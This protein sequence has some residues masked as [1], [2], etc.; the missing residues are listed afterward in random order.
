MHY[1]TFEPAL[2]SS[3]A[4]L[5]RNQMPIAYFQSYLDLARDIGLDPKKIMQD[6]GIPA[7]ILDAPD[8]RISIQKYFLLMQLIANHSGDYS[9]GFELGLRLP[10]TAH[11]HLSF[12]LLCAPDLK[13]ALSLAQ[14][15]WHLRSSG[16]Y[17]SLDVQDG[18]CAISFYADPAMPTLYQQVTLEA[19]VIGFYLALQF[20]CG[21]TWQAEIWFSNPEPD[22]FARYKD[23]FAMVSYSKPA[24]Q[25]RFAA[26]WLET[27][28]VTHHPHALKAAIEL[29]ERENVLFSQNA[30]DIVGQVRS[31]IVLGSEGYP[32]AEDIAAHLNLTPRT[33]R[34]KL[35]LDHTGYKQLLEEARLRDAL[36]MLGTTKL[37][38]QAIAQRLGYNNPANFSRA[39]RA[40]RGVS[41]RSYRLGDAADSTEA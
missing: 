27:R 37:D 39:F 31:K 10:P 3:D 11:G 12:A 19:T 29:C 7:Q 4:W 33:L 6:L 35:Q 5:N 16:N 8:N 40:W 2:A 1:A 22:Y 41:P 21:A 13:D 28:F 36:T 30:E 18:Q 14:R 32:S 20:L 23:R 9:L 24:C 38:I 34:R 15:F 17:F 26:Q 25:I